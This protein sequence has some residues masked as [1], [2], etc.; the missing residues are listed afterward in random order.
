MQRSRLRMPMGKCLRPTAITLGR[1]PFIDFLAGESGEYFIVLNDLSYRGGLPYRLVVSD[2]PF[3]ENAFPRIAKEGETLNG[4]LLGRNFGASTTVSTS[5]NADFDLSM[6]TFS[7]ATPNDILGLG[8]F[9]FLEHPTQFSMAPTA[10]TCTV[11]GFQ[12]RPKVDGRASLNT[13][14]FLTTDIDPILEKEPNDQ[15]MPQLIELPI[16]MSGRFDQPRDAD[17]F[18]F[19][20]KVNGAYSFDVYCERINGQADPYLVLF[21]QNGNR[22]QELDDFGHRINAF[23]GHLR[24]PAGTI[25]LNAGSTYR[26]LVQDRYQRGGAR[27]QYALIVRLAKPDFFV[28]AIHSLNPGPAGTTIWRGG[29]AYFDIVIHQNGGY[30]GPVTI[31]A[32]GLPPGLHTVPTTLGLGSSGTFVM[33]AD[34]DMPESTSGIRLLATGIHEGEKF[35]REVRPYTRVWN[36]G[37]GTSRPLRELMIATRSTAPFLMSFAEP[38]VSC[39]AG[40]KVQ[41]KLKLDRLWPSFQEPLNVL[42]LSWPGNFRMNNGQFSGATNEITLDIEVQAG[43]KPGEY[44]LAVLGQG[45]VPFSKNS[46]GKDMKN[47]LVSMPS[48]PLTIVVQGP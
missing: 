24:D 46:D 8:R 23:D 10:A 18:E 25:N 30:I 26:M 1:D 45:Q 7:F 29:A 39:A 44:T 4:S 11:N 42:P 34:R 31:T 19:T 36:Q 41:A 22:L 27:Y 9:R 40:K 33:W 17:W 13:T 3:V 15:S 20:P 12:I 43:T 37:D 14:T 32:D 21:D 28:A 5:K 35:V 38:Q 16:A 48:T 2:R 6:S 47:V